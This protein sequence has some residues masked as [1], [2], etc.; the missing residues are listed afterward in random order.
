MT[1]IQVIQPTGCNSFTSLSLDVYVW[2]NMFRT[3]PRP[4]SGAWNCTKSLWF[5]RWREAAGALLVVVWQTTTN[6]TPAA[7]LQRLNQRLLVQ[8]YA[9]DD[10]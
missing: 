8:L 2:L 9:P 7:S 5:Y 1:L 10:G 6:N 3:S 4:L